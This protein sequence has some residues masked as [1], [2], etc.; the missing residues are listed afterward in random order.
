MVNG[1]NAIK[2]V[3]AAEADHYLPVSL[4]GVKTRAQDT[5]IP[6]KREL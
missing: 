4:W 1:E 5:S 6:V 2:K 3:E